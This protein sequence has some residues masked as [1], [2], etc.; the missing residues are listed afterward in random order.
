MGTALAFLVLFFFSS[1]LLAV[2]L[3]EG[4][5]G[6]RTFTAPTRGPLPASLLSLPRHC[7]PALGDPRLHFSEEE[8]GQ[9]TFSLRLGSG[10]AV[11]LRT[12]VPHKG[13]LVFTRGDIP[14]STALVTDEATEARSLE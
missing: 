10:R 5:P 9:E 1:F 6:Q 3:P 4:P 8:T 11:T 14:A 13:Q 7:R 12:M 2:P